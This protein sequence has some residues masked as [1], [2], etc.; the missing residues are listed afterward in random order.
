MSESEKPT[1]LVTGGAGYIGSH[2][3]LAL[4]DAG[5]P[6]VVID[7]LT[8][9]F[10]WAV[11]GAAT[12]VQGDVADQP[13]V[14][15][16]IAEHGIG[17]I[18]HFAGS[19]V[20]PESVEKPLKYYENNTVKS[21]ALIES[22][23]EGGVGHFIFSSTAATYGIPDEVPVRETARTEPINPYGWSKLMTERMLA[24][25][26]FAHPLNYCALRYFNVAGAD[27]QGR[28]GQSTAG[29]THLIKVAVEAATGKRSHVSVF[30]TDYDTPDGTGIRDYIHVSDLA[31]AHVDA[32]EKLIANPAESYV[33]NCGYS[34]GFSV[35]EV[36]D[37]VDRVTNVTI[38][39]RLEPR[40]P[41][42]PDA[43]VA[44][45]SKILATLPWRPKRADLDTI[46]ADALAWERKL[47]ERD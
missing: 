31:A 43:L 12:F 10:E 36:L 13:L 26:A 33:M 25:A 8:T 46:V 7:N 15:G 37:S 40:R 45:N 29:A 41:G 18:M 11:P 28:S 1:V 4:L 17:A 14:A 39:R 42:D 6:V 19:I 24:D 5:W 16:V 30:G 27:P 32:L 2:A 3:V 47:A 23:V 44:D 20:V 38:E 34:R 35:L 21:R 9:G 22:A